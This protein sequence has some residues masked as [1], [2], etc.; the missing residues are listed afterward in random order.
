MTIFHV[1]LVKNYIKQQAGIG[2]WWGKN[3]CSLKNLY[4]IY[5]YLRVCVC[6]CVCVCVYAHMCTVVY[7]GQKTVSDLLDLGL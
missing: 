3:L 1:L 4:L 6:V 7:K 5:I 2:L